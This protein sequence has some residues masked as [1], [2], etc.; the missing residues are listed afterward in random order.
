MLELGGFWAYYSIWFLRA[1]PRRRA[2]LVEPDPAHIAIGKANLGLNSVEA[3]F[4]Q[5][6]LGGVP[7]SVQ[8]FTTEES[9]ALELPCID[10]CELLATR[11]IDRLTVLH[12]DAQGAELAVLQQIAPLLRQR[13]IDWVFVST[14]HHTISGD[15]LTHQRCLALLQILGAQIEVEHDIQ[16]SFSGDGLICARFVPVPPAWR[17]PKLSFNRASTSLFRDPLY[18]LAA[19]QRRS[20]PIP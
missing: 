14:H 3:E 19:V 18:D 10:I 5:G 16:E 15:P 20:P 13:R 17:A 1:A 11:G 9:G 4:V 8:T 12:C 6:F 2:I 7:G